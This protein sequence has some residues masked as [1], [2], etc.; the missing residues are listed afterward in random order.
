MRSTLSGLALIAALPAAAADYI[1]A[2][3]E[4][5]ARDQ[6]RQVHKDLL[7]LVLETA[8]PGDV[9]RVVD[10]TAL[11]T[12][13]TFAIPEGSE[14]RVANLRRRALAGALDAWGRFIRAHYVDAAGTDPDRQGQILLP[15]L[16]T[17]LATQ[18]YAGHPAEGR[19]ICVLVLGSALHRDPREPG[20]DMTAGR[21]PADGLILASQSQSPYGTAD[22]QGQLRGFYVHMLAFDRT[23]AS[24]LYALRVQRA[25][26]LFVEA[27]GGALATFTTDPATARARFA[28][29]ER[30]PGRRFAWDSTQSLQAMI[31]AERLASIANASPE[32]TPEPPTSEPVSQVPDE[33]GRFGRV[34]R[35]EQSAF[36]P[37]AG[38]IGFD[39]FRLGTGNPIYRPEDYGG[40][41]GGITVR[42]GGYFLG[43]RL[44]HSEECPSGARPTGCVAGT[45]ATPLRLDPGA[46][47]V[48]SVEDRINPHSPSLSGSPR[49]NGP[50]TMVFDR[51]VAGVGLYAGYFDRARSTA[52]RVFDREGNL[53]G[54]VVNIGAGMEYLAL[55]TDDGSERIAGLQFSLVG[56][57]P[58]GFGI[59]DVRFAT[60]RQI[61]GDR[62]PAAR[63]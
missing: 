55:V 46:P 28:T 50:I 49:L 8:A 9:I 58:A 30:K 51:D 7:D 4:T 61:A 1:V 20:F 27:Q 19:E 38:E 48:F 31:T 5:L 10:A 33:T 22:R 41:P 11:D 34:I 26:T 39:E 36:L 23:W 14:A 45:P 21:F 32:P 57:E 29:C 44:A 42:L 56:N 62:L 52:I 60:R 12:I 40:A 54:G 24:D 2:V 47:P 43:Q 59:D 37:D 53:I 18:T 25:W 15:Q 17:H 16:L 6:A 13:A 63:P 35:I 3:P